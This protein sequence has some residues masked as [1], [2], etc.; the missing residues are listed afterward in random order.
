MKRLFKKSQSADEIDSLVTL[1]H[2]AREDAQIKHQLLKILS[3]DQFNRQSALNTL[4]DDMRL[5]G[6]PE[7]LIR[8]MSNLLDD[9]VSE[10]T[11]EMLEPK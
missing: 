4:V 1:I 10:K 2:I 11:R 6:A 7:V 5:K 9:A 8:A 3:L